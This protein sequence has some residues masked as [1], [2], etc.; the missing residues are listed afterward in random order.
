MPVILALRRLRQE[1]F[2]FK[3]SVGYI[4]RPGVCKALGLIPSTAKNNC[5]CVFS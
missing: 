5:A 3:V 4:V 1:G 2:E